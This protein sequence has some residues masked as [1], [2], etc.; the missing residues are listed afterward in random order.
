MSSN[1]PHKV[2]R[3]PPLMAQICD[4]CKCKVHFKVRSSSKSS[5]NGFLTE[6]LRCPMC[7]AFARRYREIT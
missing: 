5:R 1:R 2:Q 4:N 6:Y 3:L 7:G